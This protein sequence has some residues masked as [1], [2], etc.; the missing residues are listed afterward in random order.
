M[1]KKATKRTRSYSRDFPIGDK[2]G[3]YLIEVPAPLWRKVKARA[4]REGTA[5]RS[6]MIAGL[7]AYT[8]EDGRG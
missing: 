7:L 6:V 2:P 8:Q 4:K 1:A 3:R 5:I